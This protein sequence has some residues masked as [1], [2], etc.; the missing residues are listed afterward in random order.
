MN[1]LKRI[2]KKYYNDRKLVGKHKH[3]NMKLYNKY[4][5][6]ARKIIKK[7]LGN[8]IIDH[9]NPCQQDFVILDNETYSYLEIQVC[10][11]WCQE[12]FPHRYIFLYERKAK[13]GS[14]TIFLTLNKNLTRGYLFDRGSIKNSKPR[15]LK[16][17]SREFVYDVPWGRVYPV[18]V[19]KLTRKDIDKY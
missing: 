16:K 11:D 3:F 10:A 12:K 5:V 9:P 17:W 13:Y 8:Y 19:S 6:P 1:K 18:W 7:R 15:R 14:D 2:T 4:D